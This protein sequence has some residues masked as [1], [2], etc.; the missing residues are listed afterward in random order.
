MNPAEVEFLAENQTIQIIPNFSHDRLYLICG[1]VG[2]FR[3]GIPVHVPLWL[4]L[5]LKQRQKCRLSAP[6]WMT[7]ETLT[8]VKEDES[9]SR[10]FTQMP[11][12]HYMVTTQL[13]LGA[14]P[15]DIQNAD[16]VRTLVKVSWIICCFKFMTL[17]WYFL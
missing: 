11:D 10:T 12:D 9:V 15:H 6:E 4:A 3:P 16:E 13:I 2:P 17:I 8:K 7:V 5:N 14:A 1:E